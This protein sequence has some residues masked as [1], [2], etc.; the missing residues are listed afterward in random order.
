MPLIAGVIS[1]V[2]LIIGLHDA[3]IWLMLAI[4]ASEV[5]L[6]RQK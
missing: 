4:I 5:S 1:G 3:A 6:L 2:M